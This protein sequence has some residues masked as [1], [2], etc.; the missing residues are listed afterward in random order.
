MPDGAVHSFL[1]TPPGANICLVLALG[2][3]RFCNHSL[4]WLFSM[5]YL[6]P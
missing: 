3:I 2:A 4:V 5:C 1:I 6:G